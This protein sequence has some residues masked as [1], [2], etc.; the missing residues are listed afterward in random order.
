MF[1]RGRVTCDLVPCL[2]EELS[3]EK[4]LGNAKVGALYTSE[5][6]VAPLSCLSQ[7]IVAP[8]GLVQELGGGRRILIPGK[9]FRGEGKGVERCTQPPRCVIAALLASCLTPQAALREAGGKRETELV[10]R[11][12]SLSRQP[13]EDPGEVDGGAVNPLS[14]TSPPSRQFGIRLRIRNDGDSTAKETSDESPAAPVLPPPKQEVRVRRRVSRSDV[15]CMRRV[16]G[17]RNR[18]RLKIAGTGRS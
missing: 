10:Q 7:L 12:R 16:R 11:R 6:S 15:K 5:K 8:A 17:A 2:P 9:R 3:V 18:R 14:L 4:N 13:R 1:G